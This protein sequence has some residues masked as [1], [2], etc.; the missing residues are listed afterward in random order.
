MKPALFFTLVL[1]ALPAVAG[2]MPPPDVRTFVNTADLCEHFLGEIGGPGSA[3]AQQR[4]VRTANHYC[5]AA[6]RQFKKLD[7]KYKEDKAVQVIL[8]DYRDQLAD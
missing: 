6:R 1:L 5:D 4:L 3:P 7:A 8:D 2:R